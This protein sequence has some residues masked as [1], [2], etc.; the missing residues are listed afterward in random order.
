MCGSSVG[1][2]DGDGFVSFADLLMFVDG[3]SDDG[4]DVT[5]TFTSGSTIAFAGVGNGTIND[6]DALV[7]GNG[8]IS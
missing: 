1:D 6:L 8:N 3:V 2:Q 4:T 7:Q 5:V